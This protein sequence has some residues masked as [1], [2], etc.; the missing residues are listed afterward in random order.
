VSPRRSN[1][2]PS[3]FRGAVRARRESLW[4][5]VGSTRTTIATPS[6]AV[7]LNL[8]TTAALALR[9]FT[10][11]RV[12]GMIQV[13]SDQVAVGEF[14]SGAL[15]VAVVS[16]QASAIGITALPTPITDK[17]SDLWFVYQHFMSSNSAATAASI[18]KLSTEVEY[19]S[20]AM[21]KVEDGQD[22]VFVVESDIAGVA[23]G[24]IVTHTAR[25]LIKL[26]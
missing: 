23:N 16:D 24:L 8:L 3:R 7:F 21:R 10:V 15:G 5:F 25:V 19:D 14:Q 2:N 22:V 4:L 6:T 11:V 18:A 1:F 26:H 12:R 9:P 13:V 20:K 17:G